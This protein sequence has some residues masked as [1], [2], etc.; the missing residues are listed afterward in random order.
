MYCNFRLITNGSTDQPTTR[1]AIT[2]KSLILFNHTRVYLPQILILYHFFP[3]PNF[4]SN[5][6]PVCTRCKALVRFSTAVLVSW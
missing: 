5:S 4:Y 2:S 1:A 6:S 3:V